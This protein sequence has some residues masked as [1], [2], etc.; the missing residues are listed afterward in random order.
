MP[1]LPAHVASACPA[2][3]V[4]AGKVHS[5]PFTAAVFPRYEGSPRRRSGLPKGHASPA[6][7][8]QPTSAG[9]WRLSLQ[10]GSAKG[11]LTVLVR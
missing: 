3:P 11:S 2:A 6:G 5:G 4:H 1:G 10:T 7:V 8:P 9:C